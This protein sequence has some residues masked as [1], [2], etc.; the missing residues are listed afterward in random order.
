MRRRLMRHPCGNA[1]HR[2][3][4]LWDDDQINAP[5]R[6]AP[7]NKHDLAAARMKRIRDPR[8]DRLLAGSLSLVSSKTWTIGTQVS[9]G[10]I[11]MRNEDV[12][13]LYDRVPVGAR[14][15]VI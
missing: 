9:S 10:C 5:I 2:P 7:L 15:I 12:I 3:I 8:L 4:G 1:G 13:D 11:R 14:V 6:I